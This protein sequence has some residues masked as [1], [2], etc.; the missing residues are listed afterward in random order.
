MY[1]V[2][3]TGSKQYIVQKGDV[4]D[5]ELLEAKKDGSVTFD[6]VLMYSSGDKVEVGAPYLKSVRVKGKVLDNLKDKKV[7]V[8]KFKS[9][10]NYKRKVGHR[11]DLTRVKIEEVSV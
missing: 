1:A 2:I 3:E 9:K 8:A 4:L 5:L 11:Q 10:S 7:V 6:R